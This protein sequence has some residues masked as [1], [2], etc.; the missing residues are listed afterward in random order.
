MRSTPVRVHSHA[1]DVRSG[2]HSVG[3]GGAVRCSPAGCELKVGQ[4]LTAAVAAAAC[5]SSSLRQRTAEAE[6]H[7]RYGLS[8]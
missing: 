8:E 1:L 7:F 5:R 2:R 4:R 3:T 6:E